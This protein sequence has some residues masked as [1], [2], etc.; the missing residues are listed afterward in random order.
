MKLV[1]AN[2]LIE[3]DIEENMPALLVVENPSILTEIVEGLYASSHGEEGDFILTEGNRELSIDKTVE[4]IV[5]PFAIDFNSRQIQNK[6]YNV[7]L[8]A[9]NQY[10]E[11]KAQIQTMVLRFLE[12]IIRDLPYEMIGC[13]D[14]LDLQRLFKMY[15]VRLEPDCFTVLERLTEY[16]KVMT[17]LLRK[18]LI[19]LV[20]ICCYLSECDLR[21]FAFIESQERRFLFSVGTYIIDHD[22]CIIIK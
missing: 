5:N 21:A 6:L 12:M 14:M 13:N 11:T 3:L 19:V 1:N 7:M 20:N 15:D 4:I 10:E 2:L 22:K 8:A 16:T 9:G 18:E 17:R